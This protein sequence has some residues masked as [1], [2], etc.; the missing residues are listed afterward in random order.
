MV[1]RLAASLF[2]A[3]SSR[4]HRSDGISR[5]L[6]LC[7]VHASCAA[8]THR[9]NNL[10]QGMRHPSIPSTHGHLHPNPTQLSNQ[11]RHYLHRTFYRTVELSCHLALGAA[12]SGSDTRFCQ[13]STFRF[14]RHLLSLIAKSSLDTFW[15]Y[16][17]ISSIRI[18]F[19]PFINLDSC[20]DE[21]AGV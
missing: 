21:Q 8:H 4:E 14:G 12:D 16:C 11:I 10:K 9:P 20:L 6:P 18:N 5:I 15:F 1:P 2:S 17:I 19:F 3:P 13:H 7:A